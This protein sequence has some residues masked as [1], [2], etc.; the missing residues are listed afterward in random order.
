MTT[1]GNKRAPRAPR[2]PSATALANEI[3]KQAEAEVAE[4]IELKVTNRKAST[5]KAKA[6]PAPAPTKRTRKAPR[7]D[8]I[9]DLPPALH[10]GLPTGYE[11]R[12]PHAGYDLF[13]KVDA[14][15]DGPAWYVRCNEHGEMTEASNTKDGDQKGRKA[16]RA[17]WCGECKAAGK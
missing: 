13:K 7:R 5:R 2:K 10:R 1:H 11:V 6:A 9:A 8:G 3:K 16:D 15:V 12:W 14:S 17:T 4:V